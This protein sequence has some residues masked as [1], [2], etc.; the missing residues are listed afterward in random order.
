MAA[1]DALEVYLFS[2]PKAILALLC[3]LRGV[4]LFRDTTR[5]TKEAELGDQ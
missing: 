5:A 1:E 4:D 3:F 2:E